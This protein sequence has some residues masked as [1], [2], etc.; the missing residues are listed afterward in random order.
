MVTT[1]RLS[2]GRLEGGCFGTEGGTYSTDPAH[3][4]ITFHDIE[5][6]ENFTVTFS[7]DEQGSLHLTPVPPMHPGV[8]FQC[9]SK[10]WT[11]ID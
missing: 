3:D 1:V 2:D 4:L 7:V 8:A 11:K 9:F 5:F 10:P 6:G